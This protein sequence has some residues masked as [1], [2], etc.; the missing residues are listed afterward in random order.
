MLTKHTMVCYTVTYMDTS[1]VPNPIEKAPEPVS[2]ETGIGS[3]ETIV[4]PEQTSEQAGS[5]E[6]PSAEASAPVVAVPVQSVQTAAPIVTNKDPELAKIENTLSEGLDDLYRALSP[7]KKVL[8]R[9]QGEEIALKIQVMLT[10]VKVKLSD[11]VSLIM[12]WLRTLPGVNRF[13]LEQQ[14]VIKAQKLM[15]VQKKQ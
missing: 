12:Q 9:Q 1:S 13:F 2:V 14:A 8:F 7:E 3:K 6:R 11:V 15:H 4:S 10:Q 5:T